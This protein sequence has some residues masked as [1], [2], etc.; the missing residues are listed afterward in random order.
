M[1]LTSNC[2]APQ[3][4]YSTLPWPLRWL[5]ARSARKTALALLPPSAAA[6]PAAFYAAACTALDVLADRLRSSS[7]PY[8]YGE[9]PCSLDALLCGHLA[10]Y[11]QSPVA[12]PALQAKV[13]C[14]RCAFSCKRCN[15]PVA[16]RN[17]GGTLK[18]QCGGL[19]PC[20]RS[21]MP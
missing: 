16:M 19:Q 12:A 10:F 17:E 6:D 5:L 9:R 8:F 14:L 1:P 21:G 11:R 7:G 4:A 15:V 20:S 18:A 13:G 2:N 3:A